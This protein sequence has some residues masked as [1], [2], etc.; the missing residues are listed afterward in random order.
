MPSTNNQEKKN[1][2]VIL[3]HVEDEEKGVRFPVVL[4]SP[5]VRVPLPNSSNKQSDLDVA[6]LK[7]KLSIKPTTER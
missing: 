2:N 6:C 7:N 5:S 3:S 1:M 4:L